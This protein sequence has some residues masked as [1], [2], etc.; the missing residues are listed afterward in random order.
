MSAPSR[1]IMPPVW[2]VIAMLA[3]YVLDRWLPIAEIFPWP[4][5]LVGAP[6]ILLG[7]I[8]T[9]S[10]AGA[11][12]R[13]GTPVVPFEPSTALVVR[14]WYRLTRNPMYLG[15]ALVLAGV[16]VL[17]G[18]VGALAP[19]PAFIAGLHFRFI[20]GEERFLEEIFG[21]EFRAYRSRVR[22]WV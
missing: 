19:L 14:G 8:M 3:T 17:Q 16:G 9:A 21:E 12:K 1:R 2:L 20:L 18:S 6:L 11:F 13:A 4:W 22:R 5:Y 15:L 7:I 10:S